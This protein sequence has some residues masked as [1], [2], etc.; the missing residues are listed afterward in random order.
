MGVLGFR[1]SFFFPFRMVW[2]VSYVFTLLPCHRFSFFLASEHLSRVGSLFS[3]LY[4]PFVGRMM[5]ILET[6][7][8]HSV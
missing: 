8:G 2:G 5:V 7:G 1:S 6:W 4:S 3:A